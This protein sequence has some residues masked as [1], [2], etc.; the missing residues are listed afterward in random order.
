MRGRRESM[1]LPRKPVSDK[2]VG[3]AGMP[4]L[5]YIPGAAFGHAGPHTF[6]GRGEIPHRR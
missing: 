3:C 1:I 5:C 4:A 2:S 6:S